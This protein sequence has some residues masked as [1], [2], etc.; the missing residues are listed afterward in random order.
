VLILGIRC[1]SVGVTFLILAAM[2]RLDAAGQINALSAEAAG[3]RRTLQALFLY[4]GGL[5]VMGQMFFI[6][7]DTWDVVLHTTGCY[8]ALGI[9]VPIALAAIWRA[10]GNRWACT[11]CAS[12]YTVFLIG[13]I[14]ILPL[15][16]ASPKLGPV[17]FPVTHLVPAK[18]P[19]LIV[20]GAVALDLLWQRTRTWKNW[21]IAAV[22][23]V[24]FIAILFAVEWP[25]ANFLLS[26]ASENRFFGTIYFDYNSRPNGY[27]RMREFFNPASG[28]RLYLGLVRASVCA[29]VSTWL[30]LFF[31]DWMRGVQR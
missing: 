11:L 5:T 2:N 29:F 7:Q 1:V 21:Q 31:G 12:I 14:L 24:L 18:F 25:F 26:K 9:A 13:E 28:V 6:Q 16:P 27:D 20:V 4:V 23:G 17:Y 15:F 22:S 8:I 10:S 3:T 30:G 19:V